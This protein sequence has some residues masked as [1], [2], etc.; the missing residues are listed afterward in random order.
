MSPTSYQTAPPR[1]RN[2]DYREEGRAVKGVRCIRRGNSPDGQGAQAMP[3]SG[4]E[5]AEP[6]MEKGIQH[7]DSPEAHLIGAIV[8]DGCLTKAVAGRVPEASAQAD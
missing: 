6:S 5:P 3:E 7:P 4:N 1:V 2:G 8:H